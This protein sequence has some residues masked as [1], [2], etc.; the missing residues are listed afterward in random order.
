MS[1]KTFEELIAS[2]MVNNN[3]SDV[4]ESLIPSKGIRNKPIRKIQKITKR[5]QKELPSNEIQETIKLRTD[6]LEKLKTIAFWDQRKVHDI[7]QDAVVQYLAAYEKLNGPI[8]P[9]VK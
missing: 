7:I 1:K 5:S 4:L 6:A 3:F 8:Q 2:N 9:V